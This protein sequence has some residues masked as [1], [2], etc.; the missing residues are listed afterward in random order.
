MSYTIVLLTTTRPA[1]R[2]TAGATTCPAGLPR[3]GHALPSGIPGAVSSSQSCFLPPCSLLAFPMSNTQ[4]RYLLTHPTTSPYESAA[5]V[6]TSGTPSQHKRVPRNELRSLGN[7]RRTVRHPAARR[8]RQAAPTRGLWRWG[9]RP[10]GRPCPSRPG[11]RGAAAG[12]PS[13]RS[14]WRRGSRGRGRV[15]RGREGR[16]RA[17]WGQ[18][19]ARERLW[20]DGLGW[21]GL[22]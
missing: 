5:A 22:W 10:A 15:E 9:W 13:R 8:C 4:H 19:D 1:A 11:R 18:V 2:C 16:R 3:S 7:T 14:G 12:R 6:N 21:D 20:R 17:A